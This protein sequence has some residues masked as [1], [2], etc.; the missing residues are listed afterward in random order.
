VKDVAQ[1]KPARERI[2]DAAAAVM[3][4][5]GVANA[6][7]KAIAAEAGYSEA[8]LY[9]HFADKQEL[10]LLVLKE[11][12]PALSDLPKP[13]DGDARENLISLIAKLTNYYA[14]LFPMSVSIFSEPELLVQHREGVKRH[15]GLGPVGPIVLV[16]R[17]L[18]AE[19]DGGRLDLRDVGAAARLLA[20][21]AFQQGFL[22]AFE[23]L[24]K[25]PKARE[26]A[27]EAV[28]SLI[29]LAYSTSED[30]ATD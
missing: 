10:F 17:Y 9:K 6:T 5:R 14:D 7:T 21:M 11:R 27:A 15:G 19:R 12:V 29:P 26:F 1:V 23:G 8:M 18:T 4:D 2:L 25:V 16:E 22:A 13:G 30:P 24:R 28:A 20:G 3:R